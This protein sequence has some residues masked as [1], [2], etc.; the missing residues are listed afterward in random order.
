MMRTTRATLVALALGLA[1][2]GGLA[3]APLHAQDD[4]VVLDFGAPPARPAA[5]PTI[6]DSIVARA[7]E[8]FNA[9]PPA[10]SRSYGGTVQVAAA[11]EGN[12]GAFQGDLLVLA[13][14]HGS[15]VVI[16]GD[17][18]VTA[19]GRITGDVIVLGGRFAAD[20]GA[21]IDGR[22]IEYRRRAP[23]RREPD[24]RLAPAE[25]APSLRELAGRA[26]V[27]VGPAV[28]TPRFGLGTYNRVEG[29]PLRGGVS[30][31]LTDPTGLAL[32]LDADLIVRTARDPSNSRGDAG[33]DLR[34][35]AAVPG[36]AFTAGLEAGNRIVP[37]ADQ[38]FSPLESALSAFFLRRD[39]RDW[40]RT[41]GGGL[42]GAWTPT[43]RLTVRG[44][45][46]VARERS[47]AAVDAFSLLRSDQTWRPNPLVDDGRYTAIELSAAW[48]SRRNRSAPSNGW[49]L[50]AGVRRTSSNDL[51]PIA[52]PEQV[53]DPLPTEGYASWEASF[54]VRREQR[55]D[56]NTTLR[57][58]LS[59]SGWLGGDPLTIQRRQALRGGDELPG[60]AFRALRCDPRRRPDPA[61][62]ALC[63]RRMTAQVELRRT[64]DLRLTTALGPYALGLEQPDLVLFADAGSA[65]LAGDGPGQ[66]PTNRIQALGEWRGDLGVGLDAGWAGLYLARS[67]TDDLPVRV[68]LRLQQRF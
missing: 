13:T 3:P 17:L 28:L 60:Y 4:G 61:Q 32:R 15:V 12:Y 66:V 10:T 16:N 36:G 55:L 50:S 37:T 40:V 38:H 54:S 41:Q 39:Y 57:A 47:T 58:A 48:D 46:A 11:H 44:R 29:F 7:L 34:L 67:F 6:P 33:W 19:S 22:V 51:T 53:R 14:V 30:A 9:P 65:W 68:V 1:A 5:L 35:S 49:S 59:G 63:D 52:L 8:L 64:L 43:E 20:D 27:R 21:Q 18:R 24:G 56:A 25:P 42:F 23:V 31:A 45:I 2:P 62:P 26:A